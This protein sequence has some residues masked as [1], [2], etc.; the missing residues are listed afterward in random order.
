M[1]SKGNVSYFVV[2]LDSAYDANVRMARRLA[3]SKRPC[4][5]R[6]TMAITGNDC[7]SCNARAN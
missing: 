5:C 3:F 1:T 6:F 2:S 4:M 7:T